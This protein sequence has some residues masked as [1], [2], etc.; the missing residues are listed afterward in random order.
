VEALPHR[1]RIADVGELAA[2]QVEPAA[3]ADVGLPA[4]CAIDFQQLF[5]AQD[6][7]DLRS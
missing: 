2:E 1:L 5:L 6:D 4:P 7:E 3:Y